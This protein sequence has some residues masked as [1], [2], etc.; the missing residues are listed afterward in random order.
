MLIDNETLTYLIRQL[1][2]FFAMQH[3]CIWNYYATYDNRAEV[4]EP[5]FYIFTFLF[6]LRVN[7]GFPNV[8]K[9]FIC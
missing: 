6:K 2:T 8:E 9:V 7:W 4:S 1:N 3:L 5:F